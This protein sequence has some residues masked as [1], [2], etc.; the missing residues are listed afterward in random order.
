MT[1][2]HQQSKL[3]SWKWL[4][5]SICLGIASWLGASSVAHAA[6]KLELESRT[7]I[8][9]IAQSTQEYIERAVELHKQGNYRQ[10]VELYTRMIESEYNKVNYDKIYHLRGYSY[11][12]LEQYENALSDFNQA[13][14]LNPEFANAYFQRGNIY[15]EQ[16]K[17]EKAI[18]DY[19]Q[20]IEIN[21]DYFTAYN[22]RGGIY[23]K[24]EQYQKAISDFNQAI[25]L[26]PDY[27]KAYYNRGIAY[28]YRGDIDKALTS[29]E[30][31][32]ELFQE[33][34]NEEY[35]RNAMDKIEELD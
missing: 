17:Y 18:S 13:I 15:K 28:E 14:E 25:E 20:V 1:L 33:R 3:V 29:F 34:G 24:L 16:E 8:M 9:K 4:Q 31:A 12:K 35:Y 23:A 5:W 19:S 32:A 2:V 21:P 26:N 27:A 7:T 10:A 6:T 22:N 11:L 30:R